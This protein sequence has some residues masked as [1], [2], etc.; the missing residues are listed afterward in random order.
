MPWRHQLAMMASE[1][2]AWSIETVK[3]P[4]RQVAIELRAIGRE[5]RLQA[6][7]HFF[8]KAARI[9]RGLDHQ[10]R[11][12]TDQRGLRHPAL[13]MPR[14]IVRDLATAGGMAD[15]N[16]VFEIEM[17]CEGRKVIGIMIH[18]MAVADLRGS[19]MT[20]PVMSDDTIA[21][22]EEEQHLRVPIVRR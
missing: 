7:E 9:R 8:W 18:V 3:W 1:L 17:R 15:V 20:A 10:R 13:A 21:V 22:L 12:G 2:H 11:Y 16:R 19:P 4:F 14:Q 5:L 6:V